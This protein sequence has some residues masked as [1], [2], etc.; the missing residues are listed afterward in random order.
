MSVSW[1]DVVHEQRKAAA[2]A[3]ARAEYRQRRRGYG[4]QVEPNAKLPALICVAGVLSGLVA[5]KREGRHLRSGDWRSLPIVR[6][7]AALLDGKPRPSGPARGKVKP[8]A[9]APPSAARGGNSSAAAAAALARAAQTQQ[10]VQPEPRQQ[11]PAQQVRGHHQRH[12]GK[13][14]WRPSALV[15]SSHSAQSLCWTVSSCTRHVLARNRC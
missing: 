7:V 11:R 8:R 10:P 2:I 9:V 3:Q 12:I 1:T 6:H 14:C 15:E 4:V 5:W 13:G